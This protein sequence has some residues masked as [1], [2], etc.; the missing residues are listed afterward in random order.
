M[1]L[2]LCVCVDVDWVIGKGIFTPFTAGNLPKR[3]LQG[4]HFRTLVGHFH[5]A[6]ILFVSD[7]SSPFLPGSLPGIST[8]LISV[9]FPTPLPV[10]FRPQERRCHADWQAKPGFLPQAGELQAVRHPHAREG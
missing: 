1:T 10:K 6:R 3:L 9:T 4:D 8:T 7:H 2:V 5:Q